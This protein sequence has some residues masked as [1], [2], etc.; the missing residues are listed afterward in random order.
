MHN[1]LVEEQIQQPDMV[2]GL[3]GASSINN[4]PSNHYG[5]STAYGGSQTAGGGFKRG[6]PTITSSAANGGFGI[7]ASAGTC[8]AGGGGGYY[9]GGSVYTAGGGGGSSFVSGYD[10][11]STT[12]RNQHLNINNELVNFTD[13]IINQGTNDGDGKAIVEL[14]S[15]INI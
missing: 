7:G 8:A 9:G 11:C 2:G 5:G 4:G 15:D 3:T 10:G 13:V 6:T 12:Y 1:Q 14:I